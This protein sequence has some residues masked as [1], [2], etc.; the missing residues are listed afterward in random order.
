MPDGPFEDAAELTILIEAASAF[1]TLIRTGNCAKY[2][3]AVRRAVLL[4]RFMGLL[5]YVPEE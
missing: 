2:Q 3:R 5:P 1:Q 4:A